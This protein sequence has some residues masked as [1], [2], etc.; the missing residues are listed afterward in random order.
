MTRVPETDGGIGI[1]GEVLDD[2]IVL[3]GGE[4]ER[5]RFLDLGIGKVNGDVFLDHPGDGEKVKELMQAPDPGLLLVNGRA[6]EVGDK[7]GKQAIGNVLRRRN[8]PTADK[9]VQFPETDFQGLPGSRGE[10]GDFTIIEEFGS[11][12][13]EHRG[14][15]FW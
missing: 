13:F 15:S 14:T 4:K 11:V 1:F 12:F 5:H 2:P 3:V 9:G 10:T 7:V 6:A 8:R